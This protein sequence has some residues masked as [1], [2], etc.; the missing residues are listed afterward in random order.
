MITINHIGLFLKSR[1]APATYLTQSISFP[2]AG[3]SENGIGAA[4]NLV[5]DH[6]KAA[7][8]QLFPVNPLRTG[9]GNVVAFLLK[10]KS[11]GSNKLTNGKVHRTKMND[12]E[13]RSLG[14]GVVSFKGK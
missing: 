14:Q 3:E 12:L 2:N 5:V 4:G 1:K 6:S 10:P 13:A 11:Q 8:L 9:A 7:F